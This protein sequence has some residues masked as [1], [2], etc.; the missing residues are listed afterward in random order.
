MG[1]LRDRHAGLA[2]PLPEGLDED[3]LEL[4]LF[5]KP[6][7]TPNEQRPMPDWTFV[8]KELRRR[9]VTRALLWEE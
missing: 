2:W 8:E 5:P 4:L 7:A 1:L 6:P 3:G 9:G